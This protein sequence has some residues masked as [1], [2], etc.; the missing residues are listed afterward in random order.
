MPKLTPTFKCLRDEKPHKGRSY[1]FSGNP[2]RVI[3]FYRKERRL[4]DACA[5][6]YSRPIL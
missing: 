1:G 5:M 6:G 3:R 4:V 2:G